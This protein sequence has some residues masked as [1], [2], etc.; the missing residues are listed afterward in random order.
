MELRF[1]DEKV[2]RLFN[3]T[4]KAVLIVLG[5]PRLIDYV[6]HMVNWF[7]GFLSVTVN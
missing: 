3:M 1:G 7:H 4:Q 2:L 6:T 5:K